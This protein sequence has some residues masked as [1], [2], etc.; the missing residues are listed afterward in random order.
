MFLFARDKL[1][2]MISHQG[3]GIAALDALVLPVLIG[4]IGLGVEVPVWYSEKGDL[5]TATDAAAVAAAYQVGTGNSLSAVASDEIIRNGYGTSSGITLTVN[6]PPTS[7][8]YAGNNNAVEVI[9]IIPEMAAFTKVL[10]INEVSIKSRAVA[11]NTPA[12]NGNGCI[13][14]LATSGGYTIDINGNANVSMAGC[15]MVD[16]SNNSQAV[17]VNGSATVTVQNIY[18][19]GGINSNGN[20]AINNSSPNVTNAPVVSDP[21]S[22]L[23]MPSV[24]SCNQNNFTAQHGNTTMNPGVYCN[25]I[26]FNAQANVT[27]NPGTYIVNGGTFN[28]NGQAT[29]A[30]SGVT[31]VF[32]N[33]STIDVNGNSTVTLSAPT[34][35]TYAGILFYTDRSMSTE[36]N[37]FNGGS[38]MSLSGIIYMPTQNLIFNGGT[39][40]TASCL[41]MVSYEVTINGGANLSSTCPSGY[42]SLPVT[43]GTSGVALKE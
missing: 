37:N 38:T 29:V 42:P 41:R 3:A 18:T 23:P 40:G 28:I 39:N 4:F 1:R 26:N 7:G 11:L 35:G 19:A 34:S 36:D 16:N 6:S 9:A 31:I 14:S 2:D 43:S 27:M 24:S 22:N 12:T 15:T 17:S 20:S 30:G 8:A 32:T 13:M 5:Q 33:G 25:G 10:G 21:L